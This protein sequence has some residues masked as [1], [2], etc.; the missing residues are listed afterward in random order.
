MDLANYRYGLLI[1]YYHE[2][3]IWMG[4][5]TEL[6]IYKYIKL[7]FKHVLLQ[8]YGCFCVFNIVLCSDFSHLFYISIVEIFKN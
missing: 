7:S 2:T 4:W 6:N 1:I 5:D 8:K 3:I